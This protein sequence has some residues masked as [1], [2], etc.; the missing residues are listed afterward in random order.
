MRVADGMIRAY[1][2][3]SRFTPAVC[4]FQPTC[5]EYARQAIRRYG[6]LKGSWLALLRIGR[7]HPGHPGGWD[8]VR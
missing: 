5:S 4:R 1:Q 6:V 3:V 8:P 7:C 2:W